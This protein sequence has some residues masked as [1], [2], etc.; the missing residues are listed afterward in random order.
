MALIFITGSPGAGKSEL[1]RALREHGYDAYDTDDDAL[2]RWQNKNTGYIHPKSSVKPEQRTPEFLMQHAW[3]VPRE[4]VEELAKK[5]S[6]KPIFL[7]GVANNELELR[8]LF[9]HAFALHIDDDTLIRRLQ[10]RTSND[11]GKQP[12]ELQQS[13]DVNEGSEGRYRR[14]GYTI[15]DATQ[16]IEDIVAEITAEAL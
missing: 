5:A 12:H 7:L 15:I 10:S 14:Q 16:P 6:D 11:W 13:L 9:A 2:A 4:Y 3:N 1:T 8:D